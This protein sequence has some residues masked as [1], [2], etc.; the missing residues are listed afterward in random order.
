MMKRLAILGPLVALLALAHPAAAETCVEGLVTELTWSG[1]RAPLD[2]S[3]GSV[4][5]RP[6]ISGQLGGMSF[7]MRTSS[8][9]TASQRMAL[10]N[11]RSQLM[12]AMTAQLPVALM[13][14]TVCKYDDFDILLPLLV[15]ETAIVIVPGPIDR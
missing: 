15:Q 8:P 12:A 10:A 14:R 3:P 9:P 11:M 1:Y 2:S 4:S 5:D 7:V 13:Q 6:E